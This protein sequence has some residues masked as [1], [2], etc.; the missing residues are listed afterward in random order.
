MRLL[1]MPPY[2]P[3]LNPKEYIHNHLRNKLLNNRN[4][5]GIRQIGHAIG[6]FTDRM[7]CDEVKSIAMMAPI[8]ALLSVQK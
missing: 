3:E 1:S 6:R 5:V 8:E 4:F 2:L 7:T